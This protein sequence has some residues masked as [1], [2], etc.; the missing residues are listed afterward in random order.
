V[1]GVPGATDAPPAGVCE[2]QRPTAMDGEK[3]LIVGCCTMS[4]ALLIRFIAA[5][6]PRFRTFG[7]VRLTYRG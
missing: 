4:P 3:L 2:R 5:S 7:T 1:T 6:N